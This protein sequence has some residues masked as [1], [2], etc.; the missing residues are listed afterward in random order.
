[1]V[2]IFLYFGI[3]KLSAIEG[4]Q[5][6]IESVGMPGALVYLTIVFEISAAL[7]VVIGYQTRLVAL[8]LAAFTLMTALIFH[9]PSDNPIQ[10]HLFLRNIAMVGGF[11]YLVRHGAGEWSYDNYRL[12]A[13]A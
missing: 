11:L 13:R 1:M 12:K 5:K 3:D 10:I 4:T 6:Y 7:A 9:Y 2:V 8:S